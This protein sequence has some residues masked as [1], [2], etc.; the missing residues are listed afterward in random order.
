[1]LRL[2]CMIFAADLIACRLIFFT[3]AVAFRPVSPRLGSGSLV[4]GVWL[5]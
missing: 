4:V 1:M 5:L 3:R 2:I